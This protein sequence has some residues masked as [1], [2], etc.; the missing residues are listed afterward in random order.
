MYIK[1]LSKNLFFLLLLF[2]NSCKNSE[3]SNMENQ[4][5]IIFLHHSTGRFIWNGGL[6]KIPSKLGFAGDV[7]KWFEKYNRGIQ[8]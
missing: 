5:N 8:T 1:S 4:T 3:E 2:F 7:E 6:S